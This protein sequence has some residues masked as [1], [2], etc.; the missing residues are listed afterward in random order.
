MTIYINNTRSG[1]IL[2]INVESAQDLKTALKLGDLG[3]QDVYTTVT[4]GLGII[5]IDVPAGKQLRASE[6]TVMSFVAV[7]SAPR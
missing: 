4:V 3:N 1:A 2:T 5:D 7:R 6:N